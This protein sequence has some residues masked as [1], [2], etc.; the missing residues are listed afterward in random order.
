[1]RC[2]L[3][4]QVAWHFRTL[5][6]IPICFHL[7]CSFNSDAT[8]WAP[9]CDLCGKW[10]WPGEEGWVRWCGKWYITSAK[11]ELT[12]LHFLLLYSSLIGTLLIVNC[13]LW[14]HTGYPKHAPRYNL[15]VP[16]AYCQTITLCELCSHLNSSILS[17]VGMSR[18]YLLACSSFKG[19]WRC[20]SVEWNERR[21]HQLRHIFW[22]QFAGPCVSLRKAYE[23]SWQINFIQL[24][25]MVSMTLLIYFNGNDEYVR[26][27]AVNWP[28]WIFRILVT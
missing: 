4:F 11:N 13:T 24:N 22:H 3:F 26:Q 19:F 28:S 9:G 25:K 16:Q 23:A 8:A 27:G 2:F 15:S 20:L 7:K 21:P 6:K 12:W 18:V 1:M 17:W 5:I 10:S 14:L